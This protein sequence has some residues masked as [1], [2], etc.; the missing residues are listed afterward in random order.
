[1]SPSLENLNLTIPYGWEPELVTT[2][3]SGQQVVVVTTTKQ[4]VARLEMPF[5]PIKTIKISSHGLDAM[6]H[7][8]ATEK[9]RVS[10]RISKLSSH[11]HAGK[12]PLFASSTS[13][14]CVVGHH[15]ARTK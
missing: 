6:Q 8:D 5:Y 11:L 7:G 4:Q 13:V 1:M 15:A 2:L 9:K 14:L 12:G 10:P 3:G